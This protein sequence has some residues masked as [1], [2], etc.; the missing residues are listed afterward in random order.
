MAFDMSKNAT[1]EQNLVPNDDLLNKLITKI[2]FGKNKI[3]PTI[4]KVI[5]LMTFKENN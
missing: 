3:Y 2:V 4:F 1:S 5:K